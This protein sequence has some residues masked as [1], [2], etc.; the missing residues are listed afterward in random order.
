M[1]EAIP[2]ALSRAWGGLPQAQH[3]RSA[4]AFQKRRQ[5]PQYLPQ[6]VTEWLPGPLKHPHLQEW[7]GAVLLTPLALPGA[8]LGEE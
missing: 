8:R 3:F 1:Q 4:G 7:R 5:L 2:R 6:Y